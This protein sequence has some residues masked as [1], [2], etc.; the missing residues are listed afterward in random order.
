[1][2]SPAVMAPPC[3]SA[4]FEPKNRPSTCVERKH[5]R[6]ARTGRE[7]TPQTCRLALDTN[8]TSVNIAYTTLVK[9]AC[10]WGW[11][12]SPIEARK[13]LKKGRATKT[14]DEHLN[15]CPLLQ[16]PCTHL[17]SRQSVWWPWYRLLHGR[18]AWICKLNFVFVVPPHLT[19]RV[20]DLEPVERSV[21]NG[22]DG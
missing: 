14:R 17:I 13:I 18:G 11:G 10:T 20:L 8:S 21:H 1:M 6:V 12:S 19:K 4:T 5:F 9:K 7:S 16:Q 3:S 2:N 15:L 22:Q